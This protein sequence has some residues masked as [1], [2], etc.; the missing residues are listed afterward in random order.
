[1]SKQP[2]EKR[3]VA[4]K[5]CRPERL[6]VARLDD[7]K[8][9]MSMVPQEDEE[10]VCKRLVVKAF[11]K[12]AYRVQMSNGSLA[13]EA[14][15]M[16][17]LG[18][19]KDKNPV[20][21]LACVN[22]LFAAAARAFRDA[23]TMAAIAW[24]GVRKDGGR[25]LCLALYLA[26]DMPAQMSLPACRD[27]VDFIA[28]VPVCGKL[29]AS[30]VYPAYTDG[31]SDGAVALVMASGAGD[32]PAGLVTELAGTQIPNSAKDEA[33]AFRIAVGQTP[34]LTQS[35]T[36]LL[37]V[38]DEIRE[39]LLE[40]ANPD[41]L[42]VMTLP[43]VLEG[44]GVPKAEAAAFLDE[45]LIGLGGAETASAASVIGGEY[46][47]VSGEGFHLSVDRRYSRDIRFEKDAVGRM[48]L[49]LPLRSTKLSVDG[50]ETGVASS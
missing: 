47:I 27:K 8:T 28:G 43:A 11:T 33:E 14:P 37:A 3:D 39:S 34:S 13:A 35:A 25:F 24:L 42:P 26:K 48:V 10:E 7:G 22:G 16:R 4:T 17:A 38:K 40:T 9:V 41:V 18:W 15:V 31:E 21:D 46:A 30:F 49:V 44:A 5:G 2:M 50:V 32:M 6:V 45:L 23:G 19:T 29:A 12:N 1:M 36:T 20:G